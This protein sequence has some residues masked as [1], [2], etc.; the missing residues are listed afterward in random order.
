MKPDRPRIP[1]PYPPPPAVFEPPPLPPMAAHAERSVES[2]V[3]RPDVKVQMPAASDA[4]KPTADY[5]ERARPSAIEQAARASWLAPLVALALMLLTWNMPSGT[6]SLVIAIINGALLLTGLCLG[7]VAL[8]AMNRAPSPRIRTQ[9][10]VGVGLSLLIIVVMIWAKFFTQPARR[11]VATTGL[12]P[13]GAMSGVAASQPRDPIF[14]FPGWIGVAGEARAS[15]LVVSIADDAP[16]TREFKKK[17]SKDFEVLR[18]TVNTSNAP[19]DVY[20]DT[21]RAIAHF[22]DGRTINA[23]PIREILE[24]AT[25]DK[26]KLL[27]EWMPPRQCRANTGVETNMLIPLPAGTALQSMDRVTIHVNGLPVEVRGQY[28]T[29]EEKSQRLH[30][31]PPK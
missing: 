28:M 21:S 8:A 27:G 7:V 11:A 30:R 1:P 9:A 31:P 17:F 29:V 16:E 5:I 18:L 26:E 6:G 20:V 4:E 2:K 23:L 22:A 13:I 19:Y 15:L 14:D 10:G 24:S 25:Q 12:A 3:E